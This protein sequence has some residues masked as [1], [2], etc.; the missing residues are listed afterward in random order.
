MTVKELKEILEE[1][2]EILEQY[3][4]DDKIKMETNTYFLGGARHFLG[5]SGYDGGYINL[6]YLEEQIN[7]DEEEYE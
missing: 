6:S 4:D 7:K 2:L 1:K 5:I 3:E